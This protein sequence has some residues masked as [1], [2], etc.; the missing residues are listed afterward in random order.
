MLITF[1]KEN[2]YF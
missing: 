2:K 1:S